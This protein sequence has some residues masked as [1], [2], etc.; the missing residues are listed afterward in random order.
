MTNIKMSK[1]LQNYL[2]TFNMVDIIILD[3]RGPERRIIIKTI[4]DELRKEF[5]M[6]ETFEMKPN[7]AYLSKKYNLDPRTIKK[8]YNGYNGKPKTRDKPSSLDEYFEII[9][10]K[11]S[12]D[13]I[14]VSSIYF[15]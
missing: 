10:E 5:T 2:S 4:I 1:K 14:K 15:F 12:Y 6:L 11:L 3:N 7:F 13:G 9:K 8:Y